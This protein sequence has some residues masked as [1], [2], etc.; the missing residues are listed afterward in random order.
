MKSF[1]FGETAL[2]MAIPAFRF[3]SGGPKALIIGGVHGNEP[4][5]VVASLG[6]LKAFSHEYLFKI[7][8]I[9]IPEFN[10]DGI[11]SG[12][13]LNG[14]GVDLNRNLPTNDWNP[15]AFD[16]KYPPGPKAN[17]EPENKALVKFLDLEKP[18]MIYTLHSWKP[19]LNVNG[20][21]LPEANVIARLTGYEIKNEIGYPTPGCLGTYAGLERQ[22][23]T[24][25]YEIERGLDFEK[26]LAI[27]VPA[28]LESLK[29]T[30]KRH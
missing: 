12:S 2:G 14:N 24:L 15:K 22:M 29:E 4:E 9:L 19:L 5:G 1:V 17:S 13:R 7:Q 21:C 18:M 11:L 23:P 10:M 28:I 27:H 20:A 25:T 26:I 6:L 30:E 8:I 3:G 16:P